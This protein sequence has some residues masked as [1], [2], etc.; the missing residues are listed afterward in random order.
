MFLAQM[1]APELPQLPEGPALEHLRGPIELPS[2]APWQIG[3]MIAAGM[4]LLGLL[5]WLFLRAR[6]KSAHTT[7]PYEIALSELDEAASYTADDER[8]ATLSSLALRR[9]LENGLGLRFSA[10]T[11]EEFLRSLKGDS[12]FDEN[13]QD[14]LTRVLTSFDRI[15]FAQ[16]SITENERI[17]IID[18][19]RSLIEQAH[20]STLT[21]GAG[22]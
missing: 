7:P 18:T 6:K 3:L 5:T 1:S 12:R 4:L 21:E 20:A 22:K 19:V 15:K 9:Y 14:T 13:F 11:S 16:K 17:E 2:Y 10:R 8:F